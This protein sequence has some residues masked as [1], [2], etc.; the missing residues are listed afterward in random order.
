MGFYKHEI[1]PSNSERQLLSHY[2]MQGCS[3]FPKQLP[4]GYRQVA[5]K[6]RLVAQYRFVIN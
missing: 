1:V 2:R 5:A 6:W 3:V 4:S